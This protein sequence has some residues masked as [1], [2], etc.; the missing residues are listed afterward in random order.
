MEPGSANIL[1]APR[2]CRNTA[3]QNQFLGNHRSSSGAECL[4]AFEV[5][6]SALRIRGYKLDSN[7]LSDIHAVV[8]LHYSA[9]DGGWMTRTNTPFVL[10]PVTMAANV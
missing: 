6:I 10:A 3:V 1:R 5:D 4:H 8:I 2:I 9:L 7:F